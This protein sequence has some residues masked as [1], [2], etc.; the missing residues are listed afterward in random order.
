MSFIKSP[1][2]SFVIPIYN[3]E[4]YL[5]RCIRSV[6]AQNIYNKPNYDWTEENDC[7]DNTEIIL[8][9][10]GSTDNSE[11]ICLKYQKLYP[12]NIKYISKPN[13][14][15]SDT[16]N[17]G[18][19]ETKG[20]YIWFLD[21][22][23]IISDN[24][25]FLA[26]RMFN[27][28]SEIN[29]IA[30]RVRIFDRVSTW[31]PLD[32][33]FARGTR[34]IDLEANPNYG[35]SLVNHVILKR[36]KIGNIEF[37]PVLS[38]GEDMVYINEFLIRN[39]MKY[40]VIKEGIMYYRRRKT[41]DSA[42]D[43][44]RSD[45]D[46]KTLWI[47]QSLDEYKYL[48]D[49]S[50]QF[51]KN[52]E[53][54]KFVQQLFLYVFSFRDAIGKIVD[55]EINKKLSDEVKE[56]IKLCDHRVIATNRKFPIGSRLALLNLKYEGDHW[57][58]KTQISKTGSVK[59]EDKEI[60]N[61][62]K[63]FKAIPSFISIDNKNNIVIEGRFSNID[64]QKL[65]IS[66]HFYLGKT[67]IDYTT[68]EI[69]DCMGFDYFGKIIH[70]PTGFKICFPKSKTG[71]LTFGAKFN[72]NYKIDPHSEISTKYIKLDIIHLSPNL[73]LP[74]TD[75]ENR[76]YKIDHYDKCYRLIDNIIVKP[77]DKN[78][79]L[80]FEKSRFLKILKYEKDY[81]HQV[82]N[83]IYFA[84]R[85]YYE[86]D[87]NTK[88]P[89]KYKKELQ[90]L[91]L[92]RFIKIIL[93]RCPLIK[94][95]FNQN[96]WIITDRWNRA[97][98][99]GYALYKYVK[100]Y[101]KQNNID[102]YFCIDKNSIDYTKLKNEG[103]RIIK[104]NSLKHYFKYLS[105]SIIAS[106]L[107]NDYN[108]RPVDGKMSRFLC[109]LYEFKFVH[110]WHGYLDAD[111]GKYLHRIRQG[112]D[113][114]TVVSQADKNRAFQSKYGYDPNTIKPT[115]FPRYDLLENNPKSREILLA[116]TWRFKYR[117]RYDDQLKANYNP[118]FTETDYYQFYQNLIN[119]SRIINALEQKNYTL[120]FVLHPEMFGQ[121]VDF[122]STSSN[123]IIND[124]NDNNDYNQLISDSKMLITD[125]SG[126]AFD[127]AYLNKKVIYCQYDRAILEH[128][129]LYEN[130]VDDWKDAGFGPV[131]YNYEDSIKEIVES[132]NNDCQNSDY[133]NERINSFFD[134]FDKNNSKRVFEEIL[135]LQK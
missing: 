3:V 43:A 10:D 23:D 81:R 83:N 79:G 32:Y 135:K 66:L 85:L 2:F 78:S 126:I 112:F 51:T 106:S 33:R 22:D 122:S 116:P 129:A 89:Q 114:W 111:H 6:L 59:L 38:Y 100:Q 56:V 67:E 47:E 90:K 73:Y 134:Y 58:K 76:F 125:Y 45:L 75:L 55:E 117:G 65:G 94:S 95:F 49:L 19:K 7:L 133:Y 36:D 88:Y 46:K 39:G 102:L 99:N 69:E 18:Y 74:K 113:M 27:Q 11:E 96:I 15:V 31:H 120:R 61:L 63:Q 110:L 29:C 40:G 72:P 9:N 118:N 115:G 132:I 124:N 26:D 121:R 98:D 80:L 57:Y 103:F 25:L 71:K 53:I 34:V 62:K 41:D 101:S 97:S 84:L 82:F 128:L 5:E 104:K 12:N 4:L 44:R 35:T 48:F 42:M 109:G 92:I 64:Y 108:S 131:L 68:F 52:G 70:K 119:D 91:F 123:I 20:K 24:C 60:L 105:S 77:L 93:T 37:N 13:S 1:L 107:A 86:I 16:R 130:I 17:T 14:G 87:K 54:A 8:V 127:F 30:F 50:K 21:S 28:Y